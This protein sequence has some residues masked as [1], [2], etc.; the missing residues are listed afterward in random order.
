L[1]IAALKKG[2][3]VLATY[4]NDSLSDLKEAGA[5]ILKLDINAP[6]DVIRGFVKKISDVPQVKSNGGVDI[7][8]NNAGYVQMGAFEEVS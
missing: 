1:N 4:R 6:F 8:V 7:L 5:I 2:D 3:L